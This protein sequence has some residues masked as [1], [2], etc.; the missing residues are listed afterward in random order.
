MNQPSSN[1][2]IGKEPKAVEQ[3]ALELAQLDPRPVTNFTPDN[4]DEVTEDFL[5]G[6]IDTP[7]TATYSKMDQIDFDAKA[8]EYQAVLQEI[9]DHPGI[10]VQHHHVYKSYVE[11]C[12]RI[13]E[14]MR[15]A[16]IYRTTN[17]EA[18]KALAA[19][20]FAELNGKLYGDPQLE[21]A[22]MMVREILD[23]TS[24]QD[25]SE[26]IRVRKEF[27]D[28][29]PDTLLSR[30][31]TKRR[32]TEPSNEAKEAVERIVNLVYSPLLRHADQYIASLS[33]DRELNEQDIMLEPEAIAKV[34][35]T[36]IDEEFPETG[37][38]VVLAN[39]NAINVDTTTKTITVPEKRSSA[40]PDKVRG[41]V[42]HE[43][44][45]HMM[46]SIIG[47]KSN[48]LPLRFGLSGVGDAEEGI[49]NVM[50]SVLTDDDFRTGYQHYLT[51]T[52]LGMGQD[53]RSS[54]EIMWRYKALDSY[55]D[56]P[57]SVADESF[58]KKSK[59]DTFKFMFRSIRGTNQLPWH[60]T[61]NY[62]NGKKKIWDYIE[63]HAGD[64][65]FMIIMFMGK[66]DPTNEDHLR[67]ALDAKGRVDE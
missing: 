54:F 27:I 56:K 30:G 50:E 57:M 60:M 40:T 41:L 2:T 65:D 23:D 36:V 16:K 35:Q 8:K 66:I 3:L 45:V 53:F 44:G 29:L 62:F 24:D 26:I 48:L 31:E 55:L 34:F 64:P 4:L 46:R 51:A 1:E 13:N 17:S 11:R 42:V 5:S 37:W 33:V 6:S 22:Q 21:T 19:T 43:L 12:L 25:D 47:E 20:T 38:K 15:Q 28:L 58:I 61:L 39:A 18:D 63:K 14:L 7:N 10:P 59:K 52:L 49:A 9:L 32:L 67:G